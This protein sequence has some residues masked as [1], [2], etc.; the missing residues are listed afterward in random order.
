MHKIYSAQ[1]CFKLF[2]SAIIIC[3]CLAIPGSAFAQRT[4]SGT[5][6]DAVSGNPLAGA[7]IGVKGGAINVAS[8]A[9]GAFSIP[10]PGNNSILVVSYIGYA[11]QEFPV[12]NSNNIA[13]SLQSNSAELSQVVV[14]GYG[15]QNKKD[16]TGAVKTLKSESFNKGIITSPEQLLQGK[17]SGVNVTSASGEPGSITGITVR[18]PGGVRTGSTPLFVVDGVPLDNSSTGG[19]DPLNFINP[20]DIESMDVLKDA[21]ATAIY[22]SRGAN[23]VII[24]TTKRGKAGIS[25]LGF[26]ASAGISNLARALPVLTASEFRVEVP[27][28]GGVLDDKGANTDWQKLVTRKAITQNYNLNLSGGADKLSYYASLGVQKQQGI[29][30]KNEI[31]RYSGRFN[32]TQKFLDDR[33]TLELNLGVANTKNE[34]PPITSI[35]TDVLVNNP[36]YPA[37]DA[38]TGAI[39]AYQN[40]NN[41]LLYFE[42][43]KEITTINRVIGNISPSLRLFKGLIFK[44]NLG[45]DNSTSTRDVENLPNAVPFREGRLETF[46]NINKNTLLENYLTYSWS[47]TRHSVSALAGYSYQKIYVQQRNSSINRFVVGGVDPI[48]NPGVGQD[49]TLANNRPGGFAFINELQSYFGRVT[50]QFNNKYLF[51]ANFRADGSSKFGANNKYGYFPSFSVGW[52]ISDE[53]FMKGSVFNNLKLR[54]GWGLTGNQEIP[55]KITQAL[56]TTLSSAS[57]PLYATGA[58]PAGTT[59]SRLANPDIR[60]EQSEQTDLGLDFGLLNNALTGTIDVFRKVSNNIL[61]QVIPAD[62]VQPA[63]EVWNNVK[64]MTITNSGLEFELDY[65]HKSQNGI[66]Y[67]FGGN[68]TYMKNIVKE[69]PYSVIPAGSVSGAGITSST[70]N[71]YV[72]GEPIGTFFLKEFTGFDNAG[73]STYRDLD[74]DGIVTDKDRIAAGTALPNLLYNFYGSA[75]FKGFDL[76][77]NFNG[78]AGNK[79]YDYT[80]NV[81][82]SKLRLAKNVNTTREA[83]AVS[84]ES[85]NN[86]TPVTT[87]YIKDGAYLRLNN[88][89]LGHNFNTQTLGIRKYVSTMRFSVTGQNLFVITNYTGYDPEVNIDRAISGVSSYGIDYLSYP[90]A[91]SIIFSLNFTF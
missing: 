17:V 53:Q 25:T 47:N 48:Y 46:Y 50:Y 9:N 78:V 42:L 15:T 85:L 23:G 8:N 54:A 20:Q 44:M 10:V 77:I 7:T 81:S 31:D 65:R 70:I 57:Y 82:F 49:L 21:S 34:R 39:A 64:D 75:A 16:V 74:G 1:R 73:L 3:I 87:R 30:K 32:V 43:D 24:I 33:L 4:V 83:I 58:Y 89:T 79:I 67:N 12:G 18:G 62:P 72:N 63:P 84:T 41:P 27:K 71:G 88:V 66:T 6:R 35:L 51:T 26:S 59:Y 19:G 29:I 40:I 5:V 38:A 22:G 11:S 69:S 76:T 80:H 37:Y 2:F 13:I 61:L 86:A 91:R 45:I 14:V 56:F 60:W 36:T 90:K 28:A 68:F 55:P 52:K